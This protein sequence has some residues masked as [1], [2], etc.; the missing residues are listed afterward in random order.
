MLTE[1]MATDIND[2]A[3]WTEIRPTG[4][5]TDIGPELGLYIENKLIFTS[6]SYTLCA[7]ELIRIVNDI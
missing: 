1:V 4:A 7:E 2:G 6:W 3:A 5:K